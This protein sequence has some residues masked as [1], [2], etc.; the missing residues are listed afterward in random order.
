MAGPISLHQ[1]W[2]PFQHGCSSPSWQIWDLRSA[3][4]CGTPMADQHPCQAS[5]LLLIGPCLGP[6]R[7]AGCQRTGERA[8][9]G[10]GK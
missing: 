2:P 8:R 5:D 6:T 4:S 1:D 7:T 10:A 9:R 3:P